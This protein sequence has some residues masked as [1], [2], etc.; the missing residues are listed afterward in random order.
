MRH[1]LRD[2]RIEVQPVQVSRSNGV[3]ACL[4]MPAAA[5]KVPQGAGTTR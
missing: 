1:V 3:D 2:D 4:E 5:Q